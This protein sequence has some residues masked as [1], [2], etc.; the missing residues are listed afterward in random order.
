MNII[1][2]RAAAEIAQTVRAEK[3][4]IARAHAEFCLREMIMPCIAESAEDGKNILYVTIA[5]RGDL[6]ESR[7]LV[8]AMLKELGYAVELKNGKDLSIKW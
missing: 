6:Y 3:V 8:L 2:A 7:H 4:E 5:P 1:S